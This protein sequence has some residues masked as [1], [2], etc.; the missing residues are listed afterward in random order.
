MP[1]RFAQTL[2]AFEG[3]V[4]TMK[5]ASAVKNIEA[6]EEHL[7]T[8]DV[9]GAKGLAAELARLKRA[10]SAGQVDGDKVGASMAKLAE[11]TGKIAGRVEGKKADQ[12]RALAE[13]LGKA[14]GG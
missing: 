9:T 10:L 8:L 3:D 14:R 1:A 7:A 13:A 6:W 2:K 12:V 5:P 11:M 4:T